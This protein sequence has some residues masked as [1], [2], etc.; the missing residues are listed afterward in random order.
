MIPLHRFETHV[1]PMYTILN[2]KNNIYDWFDIPI[3]KHCI[4][5]NNKEL[6]NHQII[7][8]CGIQSNSIIYLEDLNIYLLNKKNKIPSDF[9]KQKVI[10]QCG[11]LF[12]SI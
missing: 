3:E 8:E 10:L 11:S 9:Q 5:F 1:H 4:T 12:K 6:E 7:S 2:I